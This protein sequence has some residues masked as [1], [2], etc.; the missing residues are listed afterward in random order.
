MSS[1]KLNVIALISGGKDSFFSLIHCLEQGHQI[2]ALANLFPGPAPDSSS[3]I[4][5]GQ[6]PFR[7]ED[8]TKAEPETN[9][10]TPSD[11]SSPVGF[12]RIDPGTWTPQPPDPATGDHDSLR[13]GQGS[14]E[15]SDTD[16]NSFMYQTVGH[17]VLPLYADA[18]GLPLYRL[19][20]TGRAVRHERDYD[21]TADAQDK[22]QESDETE[23]ML[24]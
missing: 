11:L 7:Q 16:L 17:E 5:G 18:T 14:G 2:V 12:Q 8:A 24:P 15:S 21:A 22:V 9:L 6:S 23:S 10:Q 1:E 3:A 19:P 13:Q 20:I 4:S